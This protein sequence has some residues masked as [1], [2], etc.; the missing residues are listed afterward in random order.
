MSNSR[1]N[2]RMIAENTLKLLERGFFENKEN[3]LVDLKIPQKLAEQNTKVYTPL[4]SIN[5]K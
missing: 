3:E 4:R 1:S 5:S 2:R